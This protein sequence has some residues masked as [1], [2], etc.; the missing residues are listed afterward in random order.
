MTR[1]REA[2]PAFFL[3]G[4]PSDKGGFEYAE[5]GPEALPGNPASYLD[6]RLDNRKYVSYEINN[7]LVSQ[8]QVVVYA[9]SYPI[10]PND[11][12]INRGAFLA[13]GFVTT[14]TPTLHTASGWIGHVG[15]IAEALI[16]GFILAPRLFLFQA[17]VVLAPLDSFQI[18]V[19][20]LALFVVDEP[21]QFVE[22]GSFV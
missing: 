7:L 4:T 21:R 6:R 5:L 1:T 10:N 16:F 2:N 8:L 12:E 3:C 14:T 9:Q 13:V 17:G 22:I 20:H 15:E 11:S 18:A 19:N